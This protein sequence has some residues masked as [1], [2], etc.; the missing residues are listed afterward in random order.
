[1]CVW[2]S[3]QIR[4]PANI[5]VVCGGVSKSNLRLK[6]RVRIHENNIAGT[7]PIKHTSNWSHVCHICVK[8]CNSAG[9]TVHRSKQRLWNDNHQQGQIKLSNDEPGQDLNEWPST[10]TKYCNLSSVRRTTQRLLNN[11]HQ[12]LLRLSNDELGQVLNVWLS[13]STKYC[14]VSS[15]RRTKLRLLNNNH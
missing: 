2:V 14:N 11:N 6:R 12:R 1:M 7:D 4:P 8:P 13:T 3:E 5:C 15:V 10:S 9:T